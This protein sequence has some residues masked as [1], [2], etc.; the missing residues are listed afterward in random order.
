M[1]KISIKTNNHIMYFDIITEDI[2]ENLNNTNVIS[3]NNIYFSK[4]YIND[5]ID[6]VVS[7]LN[8]II[9]KNNISTVNISDNTLTPLCLKLINNLNH[10]T[11]LILSY[12]KPITYEEFMLLLDNKHLK[13]INIYDI[14]SY[15]LERLDINKNLEV[16]IRNEIL[17]ISNFMNDNNI[18]TYSDIFYKKEITITEFQEKDYLDF[19]SF[20]EINKYLII[21]NIKYYSKKQFDYIFKK[22]I[23]QNLKNIRINFIESTLNLNEIFT[24]INNFKKTN[25]DFIINNNISFKIIYS[26]KYKKDNFLKQV[27]LNIIKVSLL[28]IIIAIGTMITINLYRNYND[29][30]KYS[31]IEKDLNKLILDIKKDTEKP[32]EDIIFIEP[33]E[34]D[35]NKLTETTTT[36]TTIY[37]VKYEKVFEKLLEI[38]KDTKGWLTVN[39]TNIDYPVVQ[40]KDNDYYLNKD[41]YQ[42]K[43]RHGWLFMDF[44]N[45]IFD[46]SDNTII[47][48]H[49]LANQKMF[50]TLRYASNPTWY[51]KTNNQTITFNT[52]NE[53]MKWQIFSIYKLPV[54]NDYLIANFSTKEEKLSFLQMLTDRSIYNFNQ[55]FDEETKILTLSTCANGNKERFVIH[56]KLIK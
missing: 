51:K 43:N 50:G 4:K 55:T 34:E 29:N 36:T 17:F 53:N 49:N 24:Y 35:L 22:I 30:E 12:D 47:Y 23:K 45:D 1:N 7:F 18:N 37:D 33:N 20:I 5:N 39:N 13:K 32:E 41:Y 11:N 16:I 2:K 42:Q 9:L 27:N 19:E 44:R 48:G 8:V 28:F 14:P 40:A 15:L 10:V 56:A 31:T 6:L 54:T 46:L 25:E 3:T 38:N 52:L 21:I 26:D